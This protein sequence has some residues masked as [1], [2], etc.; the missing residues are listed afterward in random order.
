MKPQQRPTT[1]TDIISDV[2]IKDL[3]QMIFIESMNE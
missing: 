3:S 1:T 2:K